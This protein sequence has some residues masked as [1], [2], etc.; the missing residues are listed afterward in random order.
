M[1]KTVFIILVIAVGVTA[2]WLITNQTT[3]SHTMEFN[4]AGPEGGDFSLIA[5]SGPVQL[6]DFRGK[7]VLLYFGYTFCPDICPTSLSLMTQALNALSEKELDQV[8]GIFISVDPDRD[9]PERLAKY[10]EYFHDRIMGVTGTNEEVAEIAQR[11][12]AAYQKVEGESQGGYLVDHTSVT[13]VI[14]ADGSLKENLA[15]GTPPDEI[16][17]AIREHLPK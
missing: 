9:T 2:G 13:Q 10:T 4:T 8:Q 12:G 7:V 14:A 11:Y 17:V 1:K 5:E 6:K 16:L 15:H 3:P